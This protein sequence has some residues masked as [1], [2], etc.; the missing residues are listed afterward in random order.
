MRARRVATVVL[1]LALMWPAV[2]YSQQI[3]EELYQ[4]ALYQEEVQG[5]L[6]RAIQLYEELVESFPAARDVAAK[7]QL[8]IGLCYEKLGLTEARQAYRS[9]I[10]DFPEQRDEVALAQQRLASLAQE[11]AELRRGPTF[12]KIEIASKPQN[13]VLSPDGE[14]LAF[15]SDRNVWVVPLHGNVDPHIA[16]APVKITAIDAVWDNVGH[17]SWSANGDWIAVNGNGVAYVLPAD[18]GEPQTVPMPDRGLHAYS[19]RLSLSP[20]GKILAFS[21]LQEDQVEGPNDTEKRVIYTVSVA[22]GEPQQL[23]DMWGRLPAFS[24]D[25]KAIAYVTHRQ[26]L[27]GDWGSDLWLVPASGGTPVKV[28]TSDDGRL[29]GPVWSP[30]GEFIAAHFEPGKNNYS[31]EL[32]IIPVSS[33][34]A[35]P[36]ITKIDL[37]RTSW[38]MLAGWTPDNQLGVF[39]RTPSSFVGAAGK[40]VFTVPA[41]GGKA[42][43]VTAEG[44][45]TYL[46]WSPDAKRI[47]ALWMPD[48]GDSVPT[49]QEGM[50]GSVPAGGGELTALPV[51]WGQDISAGVGLD[52]SPD[53]QK[54]VFMGGPFHGPRPGPEDVSIWTASVKS[55]ALTQLT[56]G[57]VYDAFPSWSPDGRW[58]AFLRLEEELDYDK[59]NIQLIAP[60]GGEIRQ[61]TSN[62]DSVRVA[63]IAFSPDGTRIAYF[64]GSNIKTVAVPGGRSEV[65][66]EDGTLGPFPDLAWSPDG[67]HI[68]YTTAR[69]G[70]IKVA[71]LDTGRSVELATGLSPETRYSEVAWSPDGRTIAFVAARPTEEDEF[72]LISDFLPRER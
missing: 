30:D 45:P 20:D 51:A 72:W 59:G 60:S 31:R 21:A 53:G 58:I 66:L 29:R 17:L 50:V 67:R 43:Q 32:W 5:D 69:G 62:A 40:S 7:A 12:T 6:E 3:A 26:L 42:A 10:D 22:G 13:G 71:S 56:A 36:S 46:A 39:M 61:I 54:V 33:A 19:Y 47:L 37:P 57:P 48:R 11:L 15:V 35:S 9:V 44:I 24:P 2:G 41:S 27:E 63:S 23:T 34:G 1:S 65:L 16:G 64:S 4:A 25:G 68:A 70:R 49:G 55:G 8:H 52:V 14:L 28:I 38:H 18:G